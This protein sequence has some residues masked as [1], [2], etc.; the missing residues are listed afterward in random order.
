MSLIGSSAFAGLAGCGLIDRGDPVLPPIG[1]TGQATLLAPLTGSRAALGQIMQQAASVGVGAAVPN[2][3]ISVIDSGETAEAAAAA[4][5]L[6]KDAGAK[7]ILGPLFSQQAAAVSEV[8][9]RDIP[10]ISLSN[11]ANIAGGNVFVFGITAAQST[12]AIFSFAAGRGLRKVSIVTPTGDLGDAFQETA[13]A[14]A[15]NL[16]ITLGASNPRDTA[17]DLIAK[18]RADHGGAL[19]DAVYLP[20]VGGGF[21]TAAAKLKSAGVQILGSDQ[22]SAIDAGRIAALED[23]WF[24]APDPIRFEAFSIAFQN[25][26][27]TPAGIVAGLT[28]DAVEMARVLGRLALQNRE[29]LLRE[30]GFDGIVGPYRFLKNGQCER[31]LAILKVAAGATNL[32]GTIAV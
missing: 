5:Q 24:A 32:I 15:P 26:H 29:G 3:E 19:P 27:G 20:V 8:V 30:A 18:L 14:L 2:K 12:K 23:A 28:F 10:V 7:M 25:Q 16:G 22:W 9:G 21:Q 6:A 11:N 13:Q 17:G 31:G 4:A 1:T